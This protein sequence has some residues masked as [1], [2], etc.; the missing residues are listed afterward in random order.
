MSVVPVGFRMLEYGKL[1]KFFAAFIWSVKYEC[2]RPELIGIGQ[3][4]SAAA[5]EKSSKMTPELLG[6]DDLKRPERNREEQVAEL[7]V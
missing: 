2:L 6:R 7:H 5:W 4:K 3:C 1:R